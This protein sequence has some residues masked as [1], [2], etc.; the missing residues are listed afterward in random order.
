ME[1][2]EAGDPTMG[3]TREWLHKLLRETVNRNAS[4]L[5]LKTGSP[6]AMRIDGSVRFLDMEPAPE[7]AMD[8]VA[9][10][11][12]GRGRSTF[13]EAGEEDVA[14]HVE[15]IGRFRVNVFRQRD[16]PGA[17]F[18]HIP[19]DIPS[20]KDLALPPEQLTHLAEQTHGIVLVTGVT[21][22]G[23]STTLA[24]MVD[25]MNQHFG[26]HVV[27]I[28]DPIE[29][30][31]EDGKCLIEQ[32]EVGRDTASF[33]EALKHVVRQS[34]DVILIGEMRD[35]VTIE[36]ALNA[37]EIG[38]L[39]LSTLHTATAVQTLERMV[40]YF[41]P[42]QHELVRA[43]LSNTIQGIVSQ[44]LLVRADG[45]GRVP[46]VELMM[47]SPTICDLIHKNET[48]KLRP[49][50]RED[51]YYGS[52]TYNQALRKLYEAG[53]VSMEAAMEASDRPQELKN[54]LQGLRMG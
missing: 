48:R 30:V 21:G 32:R 51:T 35:R 5:F 16:L 24:A 2:T 37:A 19:L 22:S 1:R 12:L 25:H 40:A 47:R 46:A 7:Q 38:H 3:R 34:P 49:A 28:E 45:D 4:D 44:Q 33:E 26:R 29:Y 54:E 42:Y 36:T 39:V 41:P 13:D 53:V 15:D 8:H 9:D 23:K 17:A 43:Q 14:Y 20:F 10:L 18:R 52:Q 27:T 6:P 50:M 31:H 11:V